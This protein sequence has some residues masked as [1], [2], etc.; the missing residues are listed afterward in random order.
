MKT[1][2]TGLTAGL[3]FVFGWF[4]F[5]SRVNGVYL[6]I[7][8]QAMIFALLLAFFK[9]V[10]DLTQ[11]D[12]AE[13]AQLGI[14]EADGLR[15]PHRLGQPGT[16]AEPQPRRLLHAVLS[17]DRRGQGAH[18]GNPLRRAPDEP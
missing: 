18:R 16:G 7:I 4:A 10:I 3:A 15:E 12:E 13:I 6:S 2:G 11:K 9:G 14:P 5:R 8:T 17:P 1:T